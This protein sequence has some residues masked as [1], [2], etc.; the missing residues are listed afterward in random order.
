MTS[1][2]TAP[3]ARTAA[4]RGRQ[5]ADIRLWVTLARFDLVY[6]THFKT[7]LR[8]LVDYPSL[9]A[10]TRGLYQ[11]PPLRETTDFDHIKRHYF[12]TH[13][14]L[15][16]ARIVPIGPE[17]DWKAPHGRRGLSPTEDA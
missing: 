16:P 3:T 12:V 7:N 15:N 17:L 9:W 14:R 13:P 2:P 8:R 10:Y 11:L 1:T 5:F 6:V 4:K